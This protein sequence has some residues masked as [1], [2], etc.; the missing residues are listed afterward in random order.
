MCDQARVPEEITQ[1]E[2]NDILD[3]KSSWNRKHYNKSL[4]PIM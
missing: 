4:K 1:N 3:A 2:A